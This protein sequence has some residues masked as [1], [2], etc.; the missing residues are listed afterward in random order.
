MRVA[1]NQHTVLEA[2]QQDEAHSLPLESHSPHYAFK[3][4]VCMNYDFAN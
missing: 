4:H 1:Q 3:L 2:R